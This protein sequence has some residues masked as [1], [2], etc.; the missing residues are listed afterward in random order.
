MNR[1]SKILT[2]DLVGAGN[3]ASALGKVFLEK[4]II[5]NKVYSNSIDKSRALAD[6]INAVAT[7][8]LS[9]IGRN[10]DMVI[11]AVPDKEI[12]NVS[13]ELIAGNS[14]VVHASGNQSVGDVSNHQNFGVFYPLQT[15]SANSSP[16]FNVIPICIESNSEETTLRLTE[17][18][19]LISKNVIRLDSERRRKLHLGAVTVNNFTNLLYDLA[20][21][22]L[23][24]QDVDY[25]LLLPLIDETVNKI[26][27]NS[28]H[29]SQ[30]GPAK[31]KDVDTINNHLEL[32]ENNKYLKEIYTLLSEKIIQ[33]HHDKL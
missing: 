22:Y 28:P 14:I 5:V 12:I 2:I 18:G 13:N 6:T 26:R 30:T 25:N 15:F 1:N 9:E 7:V 23:E 24:E 10:S 4:K 32:L 17:L 3:V 21:S 29:D 27:K 33:I 19:R 11:L 31:R 16:D 20:F 8:S